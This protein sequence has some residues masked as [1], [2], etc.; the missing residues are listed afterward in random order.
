LIDGSLD[1]QSNKNPAANAEGMSCLASPTSV[2]A[3]YQKLLPSEYFDRLREQD[4]LRENQRVYHAQVVMW[5]MIRQR[6]QGGTMASSVLELIRSLPSGFWPRPCKRLQPGPDGQRVKLSENTA[7]YNNARQALP[8]GVV[9]ECFDLVFAKLT[10]EANGTLPGA[11]RMF[12]LDGTSAR[13]PSSEQLCQTY[14]PAC[15]QNGE[16]HWPLLRMLVAHDARTGLAMRPHWGPMYGPQAVSEQGLLIQALGRLPRGATLLGDI[17]F[18]VFSV[19]YTADQRGHPL[20]LRLQSV[21]AERL[22]GGGSLRDGMDRRISWRPTR[23]DRKSHPELPADACVL[24]RVIVRRVQPSN[25]SQP[26]LLALFTTLE[27]PSEEI[28]PLYGRRWNIETDLRTLKGTL[29][30]EQIACTSPEMV[31]KELMM[32]MLAYNLIRAVTYLAAQAA[33]LEPRAFSFTQVRN[34]INAFAPLIAAA[35]DPDEAQRLNQDMMYYAGRA[36]LPKR[37]RPSYPRGVWGKPHTY[38]KRRK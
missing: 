9:E 33:G 26:I 8:V 38:P 12:I 34:V 37:N 5:L 6:M 20:V 24:G 4:K 22:L 29:Q 32:G 27:G 1:S 36:R 30:M 18:G 21:R 14:P 23:D 19:A 28:V 7:S 35:R 13:M 2:L 10:A 31:A 15:N 25:G 11:D 17:N 3:L 16:S